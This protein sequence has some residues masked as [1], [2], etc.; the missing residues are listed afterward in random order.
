MDLI[1]PFCGGAR[2]LSARPRRFNSLPDVVFLDLG[3]LPWGT[4]SNK[5]WEGWRTTHVFF[6][7]GED[8][9]AAGGA[10]AA[11]PP[12]CPTGWSSRLVALSHREAG[13][14]TSGRWSVVAWYP[15]LI[16]FSEPLPVVPQSWF[17]LFSYIK[18][19][20]RT[21]PHP[22]PPD[23]GVAVA[24]VVRVDGLVQDWGLFPASDLAAKV[25]VQCSF[26][27]S[28]YGYRS[29]TGLELSGLWDLPI[30]V[31]DALPGQGSTTVL[32]G[33]FQSAPTKIPR[34]QISC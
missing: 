16:P 33:F 20:E 8:T 29:L 22:S 21:T 31:L 9:D 28:G 12:P 11:P 23:W 17:P 32:R 19:R 30:S 13:G 14:A 18:D 24:S 3:S 1:R 7:S 10:R 4:G 2:V 25:L 6:C 15:P 26:S 34:G 5:Y 27:P